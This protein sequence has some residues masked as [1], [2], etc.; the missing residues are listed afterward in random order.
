MGWRCTVFLALVVAVMLA[1]S[2]CGGSREG[3]ID[4]PWV[5]CRFEQYG[6]AHGE[7]AESDLMTRVLEEQAEDITKPASEILDDLGVPSYEETC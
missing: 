1:G 4:D 7:T 3:Y 6:K 5:K 2:A